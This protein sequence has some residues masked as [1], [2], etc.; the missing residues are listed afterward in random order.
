MIPGVRPCT[1]EAWLRGDYLRRPELVSITAAQRVCHNDGGCG[2]RFS[3]VLSRHH[4]Q[5]C[6][7]RSREGDW[8]P[9][10]PPRAWSVRGSAAAG[11]PDRGCHL[12]LGPLGVARW[13][14]EHVWHQSA[15][16]SAKAEPVLV[17]YCFAKFL[18]VFS[19]SHSVFI[20]FNLSFTCSVDKILTLSMTKSLKFI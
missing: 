9:L 2:G 20:S 13:R 12:R 5:G 6:F 15:S 18:F 8:V 17:H 11:Q 19:G 10:Q 1:Q 14:P 16:K 7:R 4:E 3:P